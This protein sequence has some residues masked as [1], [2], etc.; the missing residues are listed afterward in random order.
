VAHDNK[1]LLGKRNI[2]PGKGMWSL[3]GGYVNRAEKVEDAAIRE[4]KEETNL[5]I[6]LV[7][8]ALL[9][10]YSAT[11]SPHVLIVYQAEITSSEMAQLANQPEEVSE[12]AFFGL[13]ALPNLAFM[14]EEQI[15]AAWSKR[16]NL[17]V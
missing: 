3:P 7:A 17:H 15:L 16:Q 1:I 6:K 4:I 9:G 5:D 8:D 11:G 2:N 10:V 12:L 13:D 14:F